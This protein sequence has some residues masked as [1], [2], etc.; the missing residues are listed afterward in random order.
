MATFERFKTL[1]QMSGLLLAAIFATVGTVPAT[2]EE[3]HRL[4]VTAADVAGQDAFSAA[5]SKYV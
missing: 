1:I 2:A 4:N 3:V 5:D